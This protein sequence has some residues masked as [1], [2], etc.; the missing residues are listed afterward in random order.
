MDAL[1]AALAAHP[2]EPEAAVAIAPPTERRHRHRSVGR[3]DP[4]TPV[5][6]AAVLDRDR[7]CVAAKLGESG[8]WGRL[9]LEHVKDEPRMGRRAP[10]DL[11]HLV[12]LCEGHTEPGARAGHQWNTARANRSRI[13]DYLAGQR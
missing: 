7:G 12:T 5:V 11:A 4:L 8:C 9:T 3:R 6:R 13:R 1:D 2:A 10:S